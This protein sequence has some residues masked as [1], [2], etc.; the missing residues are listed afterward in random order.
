MPIDRREF[1]KTGGVAL[2]ALKTLGPRTAFADTAASPAATAKPLGRMAWGAGTWYRP[3]TSKAAHDPATTTWIQIDLGIPQA[4][5]S[6]QLYPAF[7]PGDE[8]AKGFGF[9][10]RFR[11]EAADDP[12]FNAT[13]MIA[14]LTGTDFAEPHDQIT[15]FVAEGVSGR[16]LRLT[17]TRLRAAQDGV[18]YKL[19]LAKIDVVSGGR[20]VAMGCPVT[21]DPDLGNPN[22]L[23]QITRPPR[24]MGEGIVTDN[25]K[26]ITS[27]AQW[28]TVPFQASVPL[29]GV[30]V[31]EGQG[32]FW[33][34]MEN[35][36]TYLLGSFSVEEMLRPFRVRAGKPVRS[37]MRQPIAF[38]D[39]TLPGSSAGRF[40]MGAGNTLR[41][42]DHP[43]LRAWLNAVVDGIEECRAPNGYIMAY[44]EEMILNSERGGYT[45]AW[46]THGLIEAG[47]AGNPKAFELLRGFYDWFDQCSYLPR[48]MRGGTQG[49]QGMIANTRMYFTPVGKPEDIQVI[50]R[51]YQE[52]YWLDGLAGHNTEVV[53][54]YPYDRPHNYLITDFEAYLDVYR[55]TG[56]KRYLDAMN[57]AWDLYHD[58]WEHVG[59][60][61]AITEFG[62]FP[63]G[64][65]R[66]NAQ[67]PFCE[68]GETC[69]SVFWARFNQRFQL[70][71]PEEEKYANEIE[72]SIYNVGLANQVGSRGIIYHARLVGMKGDLPVPL[73]TN[74]C[75]EGQGTRMLGSLPEYIFSIAQD[76]LYVHLFEPSTIQWSQAGAQMKATMLGNFPMSPD[77][78]LEITSSQ[79]AQVKIRIRV[80]SWAAGPMQI[81]VNKEAAGSGKPG[82]YVTLDR[83]WS[84]GDTVAFT[85][86]MQLKLTH[87]SGLDKIEGH[88]R[89]AL[90]YGPILLALIGSDSAVLKVPGGKRHE[91][92]LQ[93]IKQDPFRPLHFSI[94]GHPEF[95]YIP[96]WQVVTEPFTCYPAIDLA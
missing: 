3:Y 7:T 2:T 38:W 27:A 42:I 44:P 45:R 25:P 19:A 95:T 89:F 65:Y 13:K 6:V 87:Y 40:M 17:A 76:G 82:S 41:W 77:V 46:V 28:R 31:R 64:S 93:R 96:Y 78:R 22:D 67:F 79:P 63:P 50:Q 8:F 35:N 36:I 60:S 23:P 34:A 58:H 24:P 68:T 21:G 83:T 52:N 75:C 88:Q 69:G 92:I 18:G 16:Y 33:R 84:T 30:T 49:V 91:D 32:L 47:Y 70:M 56:D 1:M 26:N 80:P 48:M 15:E 55:A 57:G 29:S 85:L 72:K 61:I 11:I 43:E 9:P 4:I 74:S 39:T 71:H 12:S 14:D 81:S 94:E 37:G 86:P 20:D 90:E 59:G 10:S 73:C 53:W 62:E 5:E 54:Q 51:Y 66:L